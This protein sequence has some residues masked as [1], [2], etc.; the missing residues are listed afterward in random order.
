MIRLSCVK[1]AAAEIHKSL[2]G[3]GPELIERLAQHLF[4]RGDGLIRRIH[5]LD[6]QVISLDDINSRREII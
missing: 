3:L 4:A 2:V 1:D 5:Q 6:S